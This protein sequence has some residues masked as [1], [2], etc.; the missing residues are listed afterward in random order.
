MAR[1]SKEVYVKKSVT[2]QTP[3]EN[4]ILANLQT[5]DVDFIRVSGV[6]E[7]SAQAALIGHKEFLCMAFRGT[8]EPAD[9]GPVHPT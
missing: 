1:L 9:L 5:D 4:Q 3:D 7:N 6:D 2:D 8:D